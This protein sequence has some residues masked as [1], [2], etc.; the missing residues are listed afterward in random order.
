MYAILKEDD[1]MMTSTSLLLLLVA[2]S[3]CEFAAAIRFKQV[4]SVKAFWSS[5]KC[6]NDLLD[7][8][9]VDISPCGEAEKGC[10]VVRGKKTTLTI[11]FKTKDVQALPTDKLK[12]QICG[13]KLLYCFSL[14]MTDDSA[15][16]KE[17][18]LDCPLK[19][20]KDYEFTITLPI[21][22]YY[23]LMKVQTEIRLYQDNKYLTCLV[24]PLQ[25]TKDL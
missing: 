6:Y 14:P 13:W 8:K 15:C 18:G 25:I 24:F 16:T 9:S 17:R 7:I 2:I 19:N 3:S 10:G 21:S 1:L 11:K 12:M 20:N 22:K 23:P 5:N 4:P